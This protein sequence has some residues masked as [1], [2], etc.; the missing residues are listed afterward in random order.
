MENNK[1]PTYIYALGGLEEIGKNTYIVEHD[2]EMIIV[3]TGIKFANSDLLGINGIVANYA[4]LKE[5]Q[6]KVKALFITHGHEDHIGGIP[7]LLRQVKVPVI[8]APKLACKLIERRLAENRDVKPPEIIEYNDSQ[9]FKF[10]HFTVDFFR[11]CH[12]IP[13]AHAVGI[14]T[15]NGNIVSTGDFRFDFATSGQ[16]TN[17]S[18]MMEISRRGV[19][20]LLCE[21]TSAEVNG[22]SESE[23]Y[24]IQNIRSLIA[25]STARVFVSTFASNL[26]RVEQ[27]IAAGVKMGRKI[28]ILGKSMESNVKTSRKIGYL[29]AK[30]QDFVLAKDLSKY[31][32]EEILIILTGSQGEEM[33][34]LN[35]MAQGK[36]TKVT[37]KPTD[38]I[39]LS[40]NPIPGNFANVENL[41]NQLYKQGVKV[42][43][44]SPNFKIH[45]SGHAT[46]SEQQLM[47]RA[48]SPK[49]IFPIHGEY[50][51]LRR[52]QENATDLGYQKDH[53]LIATN[54]QK[55]KL[56]NGTLS[57]TDTFVPAQPIY[58]D[59]N[60]TNADSAILLKERGV[61]SS[62]GIVNVIV[63]INRSKA[64]VNTTPIISTRGCFFAKESGA[65]VARIS[66]SVKENL[67]KEMRI[68]KTIS[69]AKIQEI[70]RG[71]T[72]SYVWKWKKKNPYIFT[73]VF[74]IA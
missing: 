12:S 70:I 51:M 18:R 4:Y 74:D 45:S 5:N 26:G 8:Y 55:L 68:N 10:K 39:I 35:V 65:L 14:Q 71:I 40:S 62:D 59:G 24:I 43:E 69:D 1:K 37:L 53:I 42:Y 29:D 25:K 15:P 16:E 67:E 38:T 50:K 32:D 28:C 31:A 72:S 56:L 60:S 19:D 9:E 49:W 54:G 20:V 2:D 48:L 11:V 17:L 57:L 52:L 63:N 13:D 21:S 64:K 33:A 66:H 73:T 30:E 36:H 58:I 6:S 23:R 44:N 61:L 27:I 34:A 47:I 7:H 46:R 22:F 41:I 3:D